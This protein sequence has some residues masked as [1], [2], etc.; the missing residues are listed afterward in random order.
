MPRALVR[1]QLSRNHEELLGVTVDAPAARGSI[2]SADGL[3]IRYGA[4]TVLAHVSLDFERSESV[5]ITGPSGSGKTTLLYCLAGLERDVTGTVALHGQILSDLDPDELARL[6]L[7]NVGFVFQSADLVPELTLRQNIALPLE[8]AGMRR[9][10]VRERVTELLAMLDLDKSADR[11]PAQVSGGQ[12]QRCAVA[13]AVVARPSVVFADEPTGALDSKNRDQVLELLLDQVRRIGGL[14]I[15]VT[16][17]LDVAER[18][19]R[20]IALVDGRVVDDARR[21]NDFVDAH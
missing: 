10:Q 7:N 3:S 20:R 2:L 14:L 19:D 15:T 4:N 1:R 13:R 11:R 17:D 12:A 16:H 18:F 9:R 6:R 8:L 5:A 21:T